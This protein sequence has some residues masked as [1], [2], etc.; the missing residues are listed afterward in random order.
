LNEDKPK[1]ST[2][3][4]IIQVVVW[5]MIFITIGGVVLGAMMSFM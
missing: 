1:K 3:A 5:L 2:L 4:K